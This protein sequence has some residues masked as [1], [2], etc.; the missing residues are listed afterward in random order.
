MS[1]DLL[2]LAF[3]HLSQCLMVLLKVS[4]LPDK[5]LEGDEEKFLIPSLIQES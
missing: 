3:L 5:N 2:S 1:E 4:L